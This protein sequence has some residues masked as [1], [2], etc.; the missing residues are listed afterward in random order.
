MSKIK[1]MS[2]KSANESKLSITLLRDTN[3]IEREDAEWFIQ[4]VSEIANILASI[5]LTLKSEK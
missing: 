2:L 4:E 5:I 3:R 1:T